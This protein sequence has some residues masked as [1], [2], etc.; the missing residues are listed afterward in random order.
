MAK[1]NAIQP[2]FDFTG[3]SDSDMNTIIALADAYIKRFTELK[4]QAIEAQLDRFDEEPTQQATL[5][6]MPLATISH[7]KPGEGKWVVKD[8][9]SYATWLAQHGA[10]GAVQTVLVPTE[11][12]VTS[13]YLSAV[14]ELIGKGEIPQG[15]EYKPGTKATLAVKLNADFAQLFT[16]QIQQEAMSMLQLADCPAE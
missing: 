3:Q 2:E 5:N 10:D 1:N 16:Q 15:V 4:K 12:A 11:D 6:G 8:P 14:I 9:Y 7:R 13:E